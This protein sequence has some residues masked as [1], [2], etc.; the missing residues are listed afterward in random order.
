MH[1]SLVV[2]RD[3]LHSP[4]AESILTAESVAVYTS[5]SPSQHN[6]S[7]QKFMPKI[8]CMCATV[9]GCEGVWVCVCAP[10]QFMHSILSLPLWSHF[11]LFSCFLYL[12]FLLFYLL[13][14][15]S[16]FLLAFP[17][18]RSCLWT[19]VACH[20]VCVCVYVRVYVCVTATC[21]ASHL[22][23]FAP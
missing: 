9:R 6:Y 15:C 16:C 23:S 7:I 2:T 20:G 14:F 11:N 12:C 13:S 21:P 4:F 1:L 10:M 18:M 3:S 22:F 5:T 8:R 19:E 17:G